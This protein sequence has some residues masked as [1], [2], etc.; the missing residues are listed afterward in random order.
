MM[1]K[2]QVDVAEAI[3]SLAALNRN[4]DYLMLERS[5]E[6]IDNQ[7]FYEKMIDLREVVNQTLHFAGSCLVDSLKSDLEEETHRI[8]ASKSVV[9]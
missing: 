1:D 4:F 9:F 3:N 7:E 8:F 6:N 5:L 2:R